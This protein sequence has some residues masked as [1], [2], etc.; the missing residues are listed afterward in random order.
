[1]RMTVSILLGLAMVP[2]MGVHAQQRPAAAQASMRPGQPQVIAQQRAPAVA[3]HAPWDSLRRQLGTRN[4]VML[5]WDSELDDAVSTRYREVET[6][7]R[8][9]RASAAQA[10]G[11]TYTHAGPVGMTV[12]GASAG[13]HQRTERFLE[14]DVPSG[15]RAR[16]ESRSIQ[17]QFMDHLRQ[18]G[19]R[20]IDRTL[21]T[22]LAG[23]SVEDERP[24][25]HAIETRA[26]AGHADYLMQV[27]SEADPGT[28][29]G[30][31]FHVTLLSVA[32]GETLLQFETPAET[33]PAAPGR[34]VATANGFERETPQ[35]DGVAD[36]ARALALETA[37]RMDGALHR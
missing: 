17:S 8:S 22:R 1:M 3:A 34:Y 37:R 5:F 19:V 16:G 36:T 33:E 35:R 9:S 2:P 13:T 31:S 24:N 27:T 25:V 21:A 14:A 20:F 18:G 23:Q 26:L 4:R 15:P 12:A 29:S 30:R 32:S 28:A 7:D 6:V 11:V 10:D